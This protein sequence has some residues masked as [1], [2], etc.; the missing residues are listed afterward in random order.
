[1][2]SSIVQA[3]AEENSSFSTPRDIGPAQGSMNNRGLLCENEEQMASH[4]RNQKYRKKGR[5]SGSVEEDRQNIKE[6]I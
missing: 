2:V 5:F 1:M 3:N 6:F 4:Q